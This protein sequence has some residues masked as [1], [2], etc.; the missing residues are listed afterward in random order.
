[1]KVAAYSDVRIH[2]IDNMHVKII[3]GMLLVFKK[4][5]TS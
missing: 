4:L 5:F 1:M 3:W 2:M